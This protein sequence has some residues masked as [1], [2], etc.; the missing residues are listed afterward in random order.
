MGGLSYQGTTIEISGDGGTSYTKIGNLTGH[1]RAGGGKTEIDTTDSDS[2]SKEFVFGVKDNGTLTVNVNYNPEEAG[3][4]LCEA[5]EA[6]TVLADFKITF[7]NPVTPI[8]GAGTVKEFQ[9]N[10]INTSDGGSVDDK[11]TATIELKISGDITTTPA[12]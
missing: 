4:K 8:T 5:N 11:F 12:T 6:T 7:P 2:T 9:A 3:Y 10:V 1:Q